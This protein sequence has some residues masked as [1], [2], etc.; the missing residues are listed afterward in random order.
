M[1]KQRMETSSFLPVASST[2]QP[3]MLN[4]LEPVSVTLDILVLI[5]RYDSVQVVRIQWEAKVMSMVDH[6]LDVGT[7]GIMENASAIQDFLEPNVKNSVQMSFK[8][9]VA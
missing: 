6:A 2:L 7:V 5:V 3:L 4:S 9:S 1:F 8:H